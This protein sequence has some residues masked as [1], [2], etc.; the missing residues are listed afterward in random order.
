MS[1][2]REL[3]L[4]RGHVPDLVY[5]RRERL[6]S[7][8][9]TTSAFLRRS[10][11]QARSPFRRT[12]RTHLDNPISR[13]GSEPLVPR[14]DRNSP[15]PPKMPTNDPHQLPLRMVIRLDLTRFSAANEGLGEKSW[16]SV[17]DGLV[18]S[19]SGGG[20]VVYCLCLR[21]LGTYSK[22]ERSAIVLQSETA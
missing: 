10:P 20:E 3:E 11:S 8:S 1:R 14:F 9:W 22:A 16:R 5:E 6:A 21:R 2:K 19:E 13:T 17:R 18:E 4:A 12:N 15:H 7:A